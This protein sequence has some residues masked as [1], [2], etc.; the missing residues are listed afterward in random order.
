M[1]ILD[2]PITKNSQWIP[3]S[4]HHTKEKNWASWM[5]V[6]SLHWLGGISIFNSVGNHFWPRLMEGAWIVGTKS[7]VPISECFTYHS[8]ILWPLRE[9]ANKER[10]QPRHHSILWTCLNTT[11]VRHR[12]RHSWRLEMLHRKGFWICW[13]YLGPQWTTTHQRTIHWMPVITQL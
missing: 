10:H 11:F 4:H 6:S 12:D 9:S 3:C 5:H 7:I 1:S 8:W 2:L 13:T